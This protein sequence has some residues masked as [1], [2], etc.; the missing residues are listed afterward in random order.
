MPVI[1]TSSNGG[2]ALPFSAG[3]GVSFFVGEL[4]GFRGGFRGADGFRGVMQWIVAL[5]LGLGEKQKVFCPW[6]LRRK[7]PGRM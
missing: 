6:I 1:I 4:F 7:P 5:P 2:E 3:C